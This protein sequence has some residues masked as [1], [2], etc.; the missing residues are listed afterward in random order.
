[1]LSI[2][3]SWANRAVM[4]LFKDAELDGVSILKLTVSASS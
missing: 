4:T 3:H 2:C 1:M